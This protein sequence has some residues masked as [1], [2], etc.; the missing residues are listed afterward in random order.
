M[1]R[2]RTEGE[3]NKGLDDSGEKKPAHDTKLSPD[4]DDKRHGRRHKDKKQ[5]SPYEIEPGQDEYVTLDHQDPRQDRNKDPHE[6]PAAYDKPRRHHND[7]RDNDNWR[8]DDNRR[9]R[10]PRD[11]DNYDEKPARY[12]DGHGRRNH[13]YEYDNRRRGQHSSS[14]D[15]G[16]TDS[17]VNTSQHSMGDGDPTMGT[18][19]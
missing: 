18:A 9:G 8:H 16:G 10:R 13:G 6:K 7:P 12:D 19:I 3:V 17:F 14:E 4:N 1:Y 15:G 5:Q 2:H 11:G